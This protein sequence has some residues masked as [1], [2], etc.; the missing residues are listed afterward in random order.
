MKTKA[1]QKKPNNQPKIPRQ[2]I[3]KNLQKNLSQT[4]NSDNQNQVYIAVK[5]MS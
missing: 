1:E 3:E 5:S 2:T 4:G